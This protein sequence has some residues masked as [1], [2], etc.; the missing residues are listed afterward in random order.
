MQI[1]YDNELVLV[2]GAASGIGRALA[3]AFAE[4]GARLVLVD[5]SAEHLA[6]TAAQIKAK[7]GTDPFVHELDITDREGCRALASKVRSEAGAVHHLVNNAGTDGK[8][9]AGTDEADTVWDRVINVNLNGLHN[10]ISAFVP[11]VLETRGTILNVGSTLSFLGKPRS[12]AY[13]ASKAAVH[14]VTQSLAIELAP[15]GVRVN[16]LAPGV[17]ESGLT[18]GLLANPQA[19]ADFLKRIPMGRASRPEEMAGAVLF[20]CS[21]HASYMTGSTITIDG[22]WRAH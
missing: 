6:A 21:S 18:A 19:L 9:D 10:M 17:T 14:N 15:R 2:T 3:L 5:R 12:V 1:R 22:G 13:A 4:A 11:H 20:A 16:M 7:G 8:A